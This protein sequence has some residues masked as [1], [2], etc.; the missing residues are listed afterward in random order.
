VAFSVT[1]L[2]RS[3][4]ICK[5]RLRVKCS[6]AKVRTEE[7]GKL[8]TKKSKSKHK[9]WQVK[10]ENMLFSDNDAYCEATTPQMPNRSFPK[11]RCDS[12]KAVA[13]WV[14]INAAMRS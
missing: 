13:E 9:L 1:L 7:A 12:H 3:P 14:S 8:K 10:V 11:R 5:Q 4:A 2:S 6:R